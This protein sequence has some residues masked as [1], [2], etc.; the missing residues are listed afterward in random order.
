MKKRIQIERKIWFKRWTNK[1]WAVF[2]SLKAVV[3]ILRLK[4]S[5]AAQSS[6]KHDVCRAFNGVGILFCCLLLLFEQHELEGCDD[7]SVIRKVICL[8]NDFHCLNIESTVY[9]DFFEFDTF[10]RYGRLF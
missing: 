5:V 2:C 3:H 10:C 6:L 7:S 8:L 4:V 9:P 1:P